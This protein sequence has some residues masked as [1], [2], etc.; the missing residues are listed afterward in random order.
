MVRTGVMLRYKPKPQLRSF[1]KLY[2]DLR[3][4]LLS[5]LNEFADDNFKFDENARKF[6]KKVENTVENEE[7]ARYEQFLLF[8]QCF[9]KTCTADT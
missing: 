7:I 1:V 2:L 3:L 9:K 8:L 4:A 6:S 5:N